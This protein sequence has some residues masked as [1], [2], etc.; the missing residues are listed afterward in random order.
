MSSSETL[1]N[2]IL[3]CGQ[4]CYAQNKWVIIGLGWIVLMV[5][6]HDVASNNYMI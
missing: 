6:V 1:T 5:C 2:P 3:I 4:M